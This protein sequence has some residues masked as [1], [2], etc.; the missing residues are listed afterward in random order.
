LSLFEL[1]GSQREARPKRFTSG[2]RTHGMVTRT[3][4]FEFYDSHVGLCRSVAKR[5]LL[6]A[7]S[8]PIIP[9]CYAQC[10]SVPHSWFAIWFAKLFT[11]NR[12]CCR[13]SSQ[14][15]PGAIR[16][17]KSRR[18]FRKR[19]GGGS[20]AKPCYRAAREIYVLFASVCAPY[21]GFSLFGRSPDAEQGN[22]RST[23]NC[24]CYPCGC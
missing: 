24:A 19:Q 16:A 22:D 8:Q 3:T 20:C 13:L 15:I 9:T 11:R 23:Y 4:V 14:A 18:S 7:I 6:F 10:R 1:F 5:V 12:F 17:A 2:I 21:G